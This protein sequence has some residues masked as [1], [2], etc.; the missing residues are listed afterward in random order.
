LVARLVAVDVRSD[1]FNRASTIKLFDEV[2]ASRSRLQRPSQYA[3]DSSPF[4]G[5][6]LLCF[7]EVPLCKKQFD[8]HAVNA[9][10]DRAVPSGHIRW[11]ATKS[12][13]RF[14]SGRRVTIFLG[15]DNLAVGVKAFGKQCPIAQ[16]DSASAAEITAHRAD[17]QLESAVIV[18]G[19]LGARAAGHPVFAQ[20]ASRFVP[21]A[22][23]AVRQAVSVLFSRRKH[24]IL[25]P[26]PDDTMPTAVSQG[27]F[28][29]KQPGS[30]KVSLDGGAHR[31]LASF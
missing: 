21:L 3:M 31:A 7:A 19:P 16:P 12:R 14:V 20:Q 8:E 6:P 30:V 26:G 13:E 24:S 9:L 2:R 29:L 23:N 18:P 11:C 22:A 17:L 25:V 4:R 28:L 15:A 1:H 5:R 10:L 27:G